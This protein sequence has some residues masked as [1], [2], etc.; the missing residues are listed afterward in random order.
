VGRWRGDPSPAT[1]SPVGTGEPWLSPRS[2]G[3]PTS[4]SHHAAPLEASTRVV[5]YLRHRVPMEP[6]GPAH[7][8]RGVRGFL[9]VVGFCHSAEMTAA[10]TL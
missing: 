2:R 4:L 5:A 3:S 6:G 8:L 9:L 10:D 1:G 7:L